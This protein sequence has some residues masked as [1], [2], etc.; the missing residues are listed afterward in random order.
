MTAAATDVAPKPT[1]RIK[2]QGRLLV[3]ASVILLCAWILV[4]LYLLLVN[5]VSGEDTIYD[6]PKSIVPPM[7][8]ESLMFFLRFD[9]VLA[10]MLNSAIV[11]SFTMVMAIAL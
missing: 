8:F 7:N 1:G 2:K 6:F 11:A 9:G 4:P 10:S 3:R 5:T